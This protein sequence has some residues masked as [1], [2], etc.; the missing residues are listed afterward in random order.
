MAERL[1]TLSRGK[2][3]TVIPNS[4]GDLFLQALGS[5]GR[6]AGQRGSGDQ[7][8]LF[9][10]ARGYPHKN[11]ALIEP[12]ARELWNRWGLRL[13]VR[14]TVT[15]AD[16]VAIGVRPNDSIEPIGSISRER[17]LDEYLRSDGVFFPTL[18]E[19]S[20]VTPLEGMALGLPVFSSNI[21]VVSEISGDAPIYFDPRSPADAAAKVGAYFTE[22]GSR[23]ERIA[24]GIEFVGG[25]PTR[26]EKAELHLAMMRRSVSPESR[27]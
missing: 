12:V 15:E 10:P 2:P 22:P 7:V 20:S 4:P 25:L 27:A 13:I 8:T 9:Y 19:T 26:R 18:N 6:P 11:H 17:C 23:S 24:A 14:S 5:G 1:R 16:L 21:S 3:V